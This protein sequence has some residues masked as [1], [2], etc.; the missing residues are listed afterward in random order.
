MGNDHLAP[1]LKCPHGLAMPPAL[2]LR[3]ARREAC[4]QCEAIND[5]GATSCDKYG[6]ACSVSLSAPEAVAVLPADSEP[7]CATPGDVTVAANTTLPSITGSTSQK[8]WRVLTRGQ[9]FLAV[10][11]KGLK[12][13]QRSAVE[14]R[15]AVPPS[16]H[17][18]TVAR[19]SARIAESRKALGPFAKAIGAR[20]RAGRVAYE[21]RP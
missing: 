14:R 9:F 15:S 17:S 12:P 2:D 4:N 13:H 20:Q 1:D 19:V 18:V 6:A 10:A 5:R 21:H 7:E 8:G 3:R 11:V 16:G